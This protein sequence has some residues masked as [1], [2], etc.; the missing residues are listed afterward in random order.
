[1]RRRDREGWIELRIDGKPTGKGRPRFG[2]GGRVYTDDRTLSAEQ[3]AR[4]AWHAAGQPRVPDGPIAMTVEIVVARPQ[5]HWRASGDLSAAGIRAPW[6]VRKP[7][8]DNALKLIA[9]AYNGLLYRDDV[10]IVHCWVLRRWCNPGE[11]DHT[12]VCVRPMPVPSMQRA[13]A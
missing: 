3:R 12:I 11:H 4:D 1:M 13:A 6:P 8:V 9:D 10:D 5:N 7:D 2:K